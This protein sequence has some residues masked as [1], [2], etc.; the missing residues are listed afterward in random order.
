MDNLNNMGLS[1]LL[2]MGNTCY[3]NSAVQ[4]LSNVQILTKYFLS[5]EFNKDKDE[6][7]P[8]YK[9]CREY[10]RLLN[11]LWEEDN[12]V[13]KPVSFKETL[14]SYKPEFKNYLQHD[15]QEVLSTLIDLLHSAL[16][17]EVDITY[18]GTIKNNLDRMEVESI[19]MWSEH[20]KKQYS[21]ILEIFYGQFHSRL[22]C[23]HCQKSS[24]NFD[25]FCLV[26]LPI[27]DKCN[28]IYD[29]FNE[30]SK[31]E[32]LNNDNKWKCE[33]C[34]QL[35]NAIKI[36]SLWKV[37][38]ILIVALKRFNSLKINSNI[39][40]PIDNMYLDL[41]KYVDGYEKYNAK[42]E[43]FG[44]INHIGSMGFGH[45]YSYCKSVDNKWYQFDDSEVIELENIRT[46]NAYVILYRK[47]K[48]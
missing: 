30:F 27:T 14:V 22:V 12:C 4:C 23:T 7:R 15:A 21:K 38:N 44:V 42:Y 36:I 13:I 29:C 32:I 40:F 8:E 18:Q 6:N 2:N 16:S 20:F 3:L 33:H 43:V 11:G 31:A 37:P 34:K 35:S 24:D 46:E 48:Q 1:G 26:T 25:P 9:M 39:T 41:E 10:Y 45:Y 28:N 19:K 47:I 17:Y 5:G